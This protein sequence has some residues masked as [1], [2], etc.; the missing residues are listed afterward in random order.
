MM[1]IQDLKTKFSKN[2]EIPKRMQVETMIELKSS[3]IQLEN[4]REILPKRMRQVSVFDQYLKTEGRNW[5]ILEK[6]MEKIKHR[7]GTCSN[8]GTP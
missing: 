3:M 5:N 4:S 6:N 1:T 2:L 7:K 8:C